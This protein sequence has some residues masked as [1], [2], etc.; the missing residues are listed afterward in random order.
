MKS[1]LSARS[2]ALFLAVALSTSHLLAADAPP[3]IYRMSQL[4]EA[5]KRAIAEDR[6]IA[7]IGTATKFLA[8]AKNL[9]GKGSHSATAYAI[10]VLQKET[11]LIYSDAETENHQEPSIVDQALHSPEA[12]YRVPG[13]II[14]TPA[15]DKVITKTFRKEDA[16]E[17]AKEFAEVLKKIRD[18]ASWHEK[19][20]AK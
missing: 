2:F 4:E 12:H 3:V 10:L 5:K 14:L 15:L 6:P 11:I 7:W 20:S 1:F 16:Q 8:P 17:R 18:K 9:T 19:K 13:V